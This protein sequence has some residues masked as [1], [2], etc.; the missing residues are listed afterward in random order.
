LKS[1]DEPVEARQ[2]LGKVVCVDRG[3]RMIAVEGKRARIL[4]S[5]RLCVRRI[6][7]WLGPVLVVV[8]RFRRRREEV[9]SP[10]ISW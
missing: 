4:H 8:R 5:V 9:R 3:G 6:R 10:V 7:R 1:C 2:V